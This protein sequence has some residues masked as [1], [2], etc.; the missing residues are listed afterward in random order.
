MQAASLL[1]TC[2]SGFAVLEVIMQVTQSLHVIPVHIRNP[3]F[4]SLPH[5]SVSQ[6]AVDLWPS[7]LYLSCTY[8]GYTT[9]NIVSCLYL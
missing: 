4:L 2:Y 3:I 9:R 7:V 5:S 1:V 8:L 6:V